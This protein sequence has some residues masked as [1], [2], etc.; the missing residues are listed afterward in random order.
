MT[1]NPAPETP[2]PISELDARNAMGT[3]EGARAWQAYAL[4]VGITAQF[5]VLQTLV[6][7]SEECLE[8]LAEMNEPSE[9]ILGFTFNRMMA[10]GIEL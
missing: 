3:P 6:D 5:H 8:A 7:E 10:L 2:N 1:D 4:A 9:V